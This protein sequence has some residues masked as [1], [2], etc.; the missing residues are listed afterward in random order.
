MKAFTM[1][2][3]IKIFDEVETQDAEF[4]E[5]NQQCGELVNRYKTLINIHKDLTLASVHASS[6]RPS[7]DMRP[8]F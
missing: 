5:T 7:L 3:L 4:I 1:T 8:H 6:K 2:E